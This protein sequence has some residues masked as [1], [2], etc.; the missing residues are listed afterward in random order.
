[1]P[2]CLALG[3][4]WG[5]HDYTAFM[6]VLGIE[7]KSSLLYGRALYTEQFL[8]LQG[9]FLLLLFINQYNH[10]LYDIYTVLGDINNLEA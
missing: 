10:Y 6:W 8:P 3:L 7:L 4:H 9:F 2:I 5:Y 1:M